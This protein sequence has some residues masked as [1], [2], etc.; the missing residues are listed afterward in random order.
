MD[1][2]Q[3]L[4]LWLMDQGQGV[5]FMGRFKRLGLGVMVR[6]QGFKGQGWVAWVWVM[7]RVRGQGFK[8]LG[9]GLGFRG[10]RVNGWIGVQGF[11]G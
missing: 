8:G 4:G 5:G 2:G 7:V 10:L 11:K 3:F 9:V 1:Y 6:G